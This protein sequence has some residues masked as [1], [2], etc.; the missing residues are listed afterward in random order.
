MV[1]RTALIALVAVPFFVA[2]SAGEDNA[3]DRNWEPEVKEGAG[4]K[5][6]S[7]CAPQTCK[8]AGKTCGTHDDGCGGQIDCG[9]CVDSAC[10]P[11]SCKDLGKT[12]GKHDDTCGSDIDCG[13]CSTCEQDAKAGNTSAD[14][15]ANLGDMT[16]TPTT[17]K[18][19]PA[20]KLGDGEEDWFK[21]KVADNGFGGNPYLTI[22]AGGAQVDVA[23]FYLCETAENFST[24][25]IQGQTQDTTVGKGC[26]GRG[27]ATL[28]ADCTGTNENG[29]AYVR[30]KKAGA[31]ATQACL[32]YA[33]DIKIE[34]DL[35]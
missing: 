6:N 14:K 3:E 17:I 9:A 7:N 23:V 30:V 1:L 15:A 5:G 27:T 4:K 2:C 29:L 28:R 25:P 35:W 24:C 26:V 12:C 16:D 21:M 10:T 18:N 33:L 34:Q 19:F 32:S 31:G 11:K 22:S 20:L 8:T 13:P